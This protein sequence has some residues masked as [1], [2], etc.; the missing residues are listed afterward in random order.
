MPL[1]NDNLLKTKL[2]IRLTQT[3]GSAYPIGN[4]KRKKRGRKRIAATS[5]RTTLIQTHSI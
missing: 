5:V 4:K 1:V 2:P 3:E